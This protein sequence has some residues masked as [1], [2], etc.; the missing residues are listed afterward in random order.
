MHL[1]GRRLFDE[2]TSPL[3]PDEYIRVTNKKEDYSHVTEGT[4][5]GSLNRNVQAWEA[6]IPE[7]GLSVAKTPEFP[8]KYAYFVKG[9]KL[10]RGTDGDVILDLKNIKVTSGL[11]SYD[12]AIKRFK[13]QIPAPKAFSNPIATIYVE[14][15]DPVTYDEAGNVIPLSQRFNPE[16]SEIT[17]SL[18]TREQIQRLDDQFTKLLRSPDQR[19]GMMV[20]ARQRL[21]RLMKDNR[22][23]IEL[24]ATQD[25][26]IDP[27]ATLDQMERERAAAVADINLEEQAELEAA[28]PAIV[29]QFADRIESAKTEATKRALNREAKARL[30]E[31]RRAIKAKFAERRKAAEASAR[32]QAQQTKGMAKEGSHQAAE[33]QKLTVSHEKLIQAIAELDALLRVFPPD[34]RGKVGGFAVLANIGLTE[35]SL[36]NFFVKR[37]DMIDREL[38]RS[39]KKE[40]DA[41]LKKLFK[42]AEPKREPGEKPKGKVSADIHSLFDTLKAATEW[43]MEETNA[44]MAKVE[45]QLNNPEITIEEEA[46]LILENALVPLFADWAHADAERRGIAIQNGERVFDRAYGDAKIQAMAKRER[47]D[48]TRQQLVKDTGKAGTKA[49]RDEKILKD[50]GLK[51]QWKNF[52]LS[53]LNFEQVLKYTFG[54]NSAIAQKL[55]DME[56]DAAY[57]KADATHQKM[58]ALDDLFARLAG[59]ALAGEKLRWRMADRGNRM[60]GRIEDKTDDQPTIKAGEIRLSQ[61]EGIAV[62]MMWRQEDG[63]R[64]MIGQVDESG[65]PVGA[66]HYGEAFAKQVESQLSP[67]AREVRAFLT[68]SYEAEH[69]SLNAVYRELNGVDLPSHRNYSPLTVKP[70]QERAGREIDPV[71]GASVQAGSSTPGSLRSR[72]TSI[73]EPDF[74]DALQTYITHTMQMEHWKAYAPFVLEANALL[75][76]R[77]V[78][79]SVTAK[80]GDQAGDVIAGW[81][82]YASMGGTRDAAAHLTINQALS[83]T[84]NRATS[85]A[86][87]G[88]AGVLAIQATQ[89]GAAAAEMPLGAYLKRFSKLMAGQLSWGE[90]M[91]SAYVQRRIQEL[92]P[93]VRQAV[94]G[95]K[96]EKPNILRHNVQKLGRLI[97]GADG[98]FTAGTYAMV[99]DYQLSQLKERGI[100]GAEA[101]AQARMEAERI[102]DRVAQPT[103]PGA[104]SLFELTASN[105]FTRTAWSFASEA[106]K[107]VG[108]IASAMMNRPLEAKVGALVYVFLINA[109]MATI[110][111]TA[112]RDMRDPEDDEIF[113]EK[114]WNFQRMALKAVTE[115]IYGIPLV[116]PA[117][118]DAIF[119]AMGVW[120][121]EGNLLDAPSRAAGPIKRIPET[122]SG[123]RTTAEVLRDVEAILGAMGL[124][125][126]NFAAAASLSHIVRDFHGV[127]ENTLPEE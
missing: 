32:S 106:R 123:E 8:A 81:M 74:K 46:H 70:M 14:S 93:V 114:H 40:Y 38:E 95:L 69:P 116:G 63:Q 9:K 60:F 67:E 42:R 55:A 92:P 78:K 16:R 109:V 98:L 101:E 19:L 39:L 4:H 90:A 21:M 111:R 118:E 121:P 83:R 88:R 104:R 36:A 102:T 50:N 99:Y 43:T 49:E 120:K 65:N 79:N 115:P 112:W 54:E 26:S 24:L 117:V 13:K 61:M 82:N 113:D 45:E 23:I 53:L 58:A 126:S 107:N 5:R 12:E 80:A 85:V 27:S 34:I 86:L 77:D 108:V 127:A 18:A 10:H 76:N 57:K 51:G 41:R 35:K 89:L 31:R 33:V 30:T 71:T 105:P 124:F 96:A 29:A 2:A 119:S 1:L 6:P 110:I 64:H 73:A 75:G 56:R 37:L 7:G 3:D 100:T 47:R 62:T 66:W 125:N 122:L 20:E 28:G 11:L 44:H 84:L 68:E 72:G 103:R 17:Y 48:K 52:I 59:G 87:V 97:G 15:A 25:T 91:K 22:P 94:D